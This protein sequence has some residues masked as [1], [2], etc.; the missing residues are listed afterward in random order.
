M[1]GYFVLVCAVSWSFFYIASVLP[2][3]VARAVVFDAGVFTPGILALVFTAW[4]Q[5]S[6]GVRKLIARLV[7][8][9]VPVWC[10]VFAV[11]YMAAAK[12]ITATMFRA[13][14]G[15]WP[16]FG[17][18]AWY[19]IAAATVFST[20]VGGQAGEEL[21][22]R[23]YGLPRLVSRLGLRSASIIIGVV[24]AVWHLPLFFWFP[25]ADKFG[26]SFP[27]YALGGVA[28]SV[29]MT[30]LYARAN[31]SLFLMMLMHSAINQSVGI[32][33]SAVPGATNAFALSSSPAA[34][35]TVGVLWAF[36]IY[37]LVGMPRHAEK[38]HSALHRPD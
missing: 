24:W 17:S 27:T 28:I 31:G 7:E 38:P 1:T 19:V 37:A 13:I 11:S 9:D 3:S 25:E 29:A 34:W 36:G 10:Y 8:V 2:D 33:S 18:E 30:W 16:S 4:Q 5:R 21:G 12:L 20:V 32:V 22:W 15:Q 14:Y 6:R 35:I 23:G 26:Q